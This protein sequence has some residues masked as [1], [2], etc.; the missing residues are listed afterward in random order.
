MSPDLRSL[1]INDLN[2][3][4]Q[5]KATEVKP[6]AQGT[7]ENPS[8]SLPSSVVNPTSAT[9]VPAPAMGNLNSV[10]LRAINTVVKYQEATRAGHTHDEA[11][12]L[13]NRRGPDKEKSNA[14]PQPPKKVL[15]A[16]RSNR[17]ERPVPSAPLAT[18][19]GARTSDK[20]RPSGSTK[21]R[22]TN[23]MQIVGPKTVRPDPVSPEIPRVVSDIPVP[24]YQDLSGVNSNDGTGLQSFNE[25][26]DR[27]LENA[28]GLKRK[29]DSHHASFPEPTTRLKTS[30]SGYVNKQAEASPTPSSAMGD[31]TRAP[32]SGGHVTE[33]TLPTVHDESTQRETPTN[34]VD[35]ENASMNVADGLA[36]PGFT[37]SPW[38]GDDDIAGDEDLADNWAESGSSDGDISTADDDED[39][40]EEDFEEESVD[41]ETISEPHSITN[42]ESA[43]QVRGYHRNTR[44]MTIRLILGYARYGPAE[45]YLLAWLQWAL[46]GIAKTS[47]LS[48]EA[49]QGS[50]SDQIEVSQYGGI[51]PN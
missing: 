29:R 12:E 39:L 51:Y 20:V 24:S 14:Q 26:R 10:E 45:H 9:A 2:T 7:S 47:S 11:V 5:S 25:V 13:A 17:P 50:S 8:S 15:T 21:S 42:D 48:G 34:L 43:H 41:E 49:P 37:E 22:A 27:H 33:K 19:T 23:I 1:L 6:A 32:L 46:T 31:A 35:T 36:L 40:N 44:T 30:H 18:G 4:Q 38:N 3:L 28:T 16:K